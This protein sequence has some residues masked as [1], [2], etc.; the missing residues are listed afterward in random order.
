MHRPFRLKRPIGPNS[1]M[2]LDDVLNT[3]RALNDLG[4]MSL[5]RYGLSTYPDE[6]MIDGIKSFQRRHN[7]RID[8]VMKPD[9]PTLGRLNQTLAERQMPQQAS[10]TSGQPNATT[11]ST[12]KVG[13][14]Q[15]AA[16]MA[17]PA[18]AYKIAE[19]FGIAVMA[20]WAWWQAMSAAERGKMRRQA[21]GEKSDGS[22]RYDCDHLHYKVDIPTCN[23]IARKRG[24][25]AAAKCF[26]SANERY[27]ACRRGVPKD[28][29]PPLDTWNN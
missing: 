25:Q 4:F 12:D 15:M 20:A 26:A 16:A 18:I 13:D 7:L 27:A 8:G 10:T 1:N 19:F 24:K 5:P 9:G 6:K 17:I 22:G 2:N 23:A 14:K 29:L 11:D 21:E 28:Q 3:K